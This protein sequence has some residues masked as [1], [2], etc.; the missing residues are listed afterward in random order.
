M[1]V[2][3]AVFICGW[4]WNCSCGV[5]QGKYDRSNY[6]YS[7]LGMRDHVLYGLISL[8]VL[9]NRKWNISFSVNV[10]KFTFWMLNRQMGI[11]RLK[12]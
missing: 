2:L 8:V 12:E 5:S 4:R 9:D 6:R 10:S 7:C 3:A 11:K 1:V